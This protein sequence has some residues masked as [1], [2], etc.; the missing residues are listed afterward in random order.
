[1]L[2]SNLPTIDSIT[3]QE[4]EKSMS[5]VTASTQNGL[6]RAGLTLLLPRIGTF[7]SLHVKPTL[8][9]LAWL[10]GRGADRERQKH[11][12]ELGDD[13]NASLLGVT[14]GYWIVYCV[15]KML[16]RFTDLH[17]ASITLEKMKTA[18]FQNALLKYLKQAISMFYDAA[19][20]TYDREQFG[21]FKSAL[22]SAKFLQKIDSKINSRIV[23]L[24]EKALPDLAATAKSAKIP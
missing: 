10:V 19:I 12:D 5:C 1:M 23:K 6:S 17:A 21:S 4:E 7:A 9:Y 18:D 14:S 3:S 8:V 11:A 16:A 24:K 20:D 22:R 15:Y 13:P 2:A